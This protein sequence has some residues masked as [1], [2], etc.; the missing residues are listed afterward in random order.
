MSLLVLGI[1]YKTAPLFIREKIAYNKFNIK[2]IINNLFL[3]K[4]CT[5]VVVIS[6]CNRFE[7]Y[8]NNVRLYFVIKF[9]NTFYDFNLI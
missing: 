4:L 7:M 1:N 2:N 6:T 5:G 8:F 3:N 9:L